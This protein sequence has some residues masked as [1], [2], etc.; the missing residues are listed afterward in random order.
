[1][2]GLSWRTSSA[3]ISK[4]ASRPS[5]RASWTIIRP[6]ATTS[7][8]SAPTRVTMPGASAFSVVKATMSSAERT[9]AWAAS[10]W[11]RAAVRACLALS[12]SACVV[13]CR[14][15]RWLCRWNW[16]SALRRSPWAAVSAAWAERRSLSSFSGSSRATVSPSRTF[17]PRPTRRSATRPPMRNA[18]A[19]WSC[20]S[21][22]PVKTRSGACR[23]GSTVTVRTRRTAGGASFSSGLQET[24]A[25]ATAAAAAKQPRCAS[26]PLPGSLRAPHRCVRTP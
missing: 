6:A 5:R 19:A 23:G 1:M 20:A 2:S 21:I 26:C 13:M 8:G 17:A 14:S 4:T 12:K 18:N 7:A 11:A 3:G 15:S 9:R 16:F 25:S 10:T 24:T 22:W